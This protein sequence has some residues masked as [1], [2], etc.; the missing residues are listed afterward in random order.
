MAKTGSLIVSSTLRSNSLFLNFFFPG[1][2][3][4]D[5]TQK[6]LA[7]NRDRRRPGLELDCW[8]LVVGRLTP[9]GSL[10]SRFNKNSIKKKTWQLE[11]RG[12]R[13]HDG[14]GKENKKHNEK[15]GR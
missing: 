3:F 14:K 9:T 8:G 11:K 12:M 2:L 1:Y 10:P 4:D 7:M 6:R 5:K 15:G 13:K